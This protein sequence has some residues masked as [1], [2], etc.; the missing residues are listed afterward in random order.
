MK[1]AMSSDEY[2]AN[3]EKHTSE[4]MQKNGGFS[5]DPPMGFMFVTL[6]GGSCSHTIECELGDAVEHFMHMSDP[7]QGSRAS[8]QMRSS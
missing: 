3:Y 6:N 4:M 8:R 5:Y 2:W 1:P 7:G